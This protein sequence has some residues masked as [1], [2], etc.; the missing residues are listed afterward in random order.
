MGAKRPGPFA[1]VI[2]CWLA[3]SLW[4]ST[5]VQGRG[6]WAWAQWGVTIRA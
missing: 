6:S 4:L 2:I 5:A 3:L 1:S